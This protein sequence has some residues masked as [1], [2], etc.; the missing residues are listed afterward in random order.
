MNNHNVLTTE[1]LLLRPFHILDAEPLYSI[2]CD[3]EVMRF[4]DGVKTKEWVQTW[5]ERYYATWGFGPYAVVEK[6]N[7]GVI[8]YCGLFYFPDVNGQPEVELGY[9]LARSSWGQGYATE[10]ACAVRDYAF[11]RLGINRLIAMIDPSNVAS[12]RVA[13]KIGMHYETEALLEGYTHPD[14]VYVI[15]RK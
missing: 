1:R 2:F 7:H 5:L 8:G 14:H 12:I 10:A 9:R 3:G 11:Y 6:H 4:S 13:E 15:T